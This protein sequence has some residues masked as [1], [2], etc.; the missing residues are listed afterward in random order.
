MYYLQNLPGRAL[1]A[2]N[3]SKPLLDTLMFR[4]TKGNASEWSGNYLLQGRLAVVAM[5]EPRNCSDIRQ[6]CPGL[7]SFRKVRAADKPA[8]PAPMM[9]RS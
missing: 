1:T 9:T 4:V 8:K 3:C 2:L 6:V 7:A 5:E